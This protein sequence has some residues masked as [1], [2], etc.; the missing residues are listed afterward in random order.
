[1]AKSEREIWFHWSWQGIWPRF[2]A[3]HWKGHA[4]SIASL[5]VLAILAFVTERHFRYPALYWLGCLV[6]VVIWWMLVTD[7]TKTERRQDDA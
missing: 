6:F 3:V 5:G 1:M 2:T 4:L 7:H